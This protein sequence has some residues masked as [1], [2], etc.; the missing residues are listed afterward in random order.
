[1]IDEDEYRRTYRKVNE[2]ACPFERAILGGPCACSLSQRLLL[3][4][5]E[6]VTCTSSEARADCQSLLEQLREN[7]RFALKLPH[8]EEPLPHGKEIKVQAGGMLGLQAVIYPEH[9]DEPRV[10]DIHDLVYW[11][12]DRFEDLDNLPYREIVKYVVS[13]QPRK[14]R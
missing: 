11:A 3:A 13:Y 5:R 9:R 2:L 8:L 12:R 7:A 10:D 4:E 6:A 1:M 14:R